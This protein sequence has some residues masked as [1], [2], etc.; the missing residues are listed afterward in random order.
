VNQA[1]TAAR[2]PL[3]AVRMEQPGVASGISL[4]VEHAPLLKRAR[5]RQG[6]YKVHETALA[7]KTLICSGNHYGKPA[8]VTSAMAGDLLLGWPQASVPIQTPDQ[9]EMVQAEIRG[10]FKSYFQGLMQ[11]YGLGHDEAVDMAKSIEADNAELARIAPSLVEVSENEPELPGQQSDDDE[12][13][14][15]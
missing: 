2:V 5:K 7:R 10:G 3:S 15:S 13:P 1:L 9:L 4:L 6:A 14:K 12:E 11:W 8:L